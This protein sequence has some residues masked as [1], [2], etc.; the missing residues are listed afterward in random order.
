[1]APAT[2]R[3]RAKAT[4]R[5]ASLVHGHHPRPL[6]LYVTETRIKD[7]PLST[8]VTADTVM[9]MDDATYGVRAMK[10]GGLFPV[11]LTLYVTGAGARTQTLPA[12]SA[13]FQVFVKDADGTA[14]AGNITVLPSTG[15]IDGAEGFALSTNYGGAL[16]EFDGTNWFVL[17][18]YGAAATV[19]VAAAPTFSPPAG[20]YASPQSVMM[21]STTPGGVPHYTRD[22]SPATASSPSS[23]NPVTVTPPEML[24]A[25][26]VAAGY[27]DSPPASASYTVPVSTTYPT[28]FGVSSLVM[29][30]P[31]QVKALT[32]RSAADPF[33]TYP[34]S[35][36][37]LDYFYFWWPATFAS[38]AAGNG[39]TLAGNPLVM[40]AL[41]GPFTGG[42]INGW[43][44]APMTI[45]GL[46]GF[47]WRTYYP[48]GNGTP[49]TVR[50]Q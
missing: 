3:P 39:F 13:G 26:T 35:G 40:A 23:P 34:M 5:A 29:L 17:A 50:V 43:Y 46:A 45:D 33:T 15:T 41:L 36:S 2:P 20:A 48:Q 11:D 12:G 16:F 25:I 44:Y 18:V 32:L 27:S 21:A 19:L 7:L 8:Q 14:A 47:L 24:N 42:P 31:T 30:T 22:G 9:A 38:P 28:Y 37:N 49:Q 10:V 1:M 4:E 6:H